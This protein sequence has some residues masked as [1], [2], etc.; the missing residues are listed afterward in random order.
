MLDVMEREIRA[1]PAYVRACLAPLRE[2]LLCLGLECGRVVMAGCGDSYYSAVAVAETFRRSSISVASV[3][4]QEAAQY[5]PLQRGDLVVLSSVS[6]TTRRTIEA[7][8]RAREARVGT[9]AITCAPASELARTCDAVL[10]LP[11]EPLSRS[12]PHTLDYTLTLLAQSL[13]AEAVGGRPIEDLDR[14]SDAL[15]EAVDEAFRVLTNALGD[16]L[17]RS[18]VF[19]L[20]AGA[21]LGTAMYGAAKLHEAGGRVA[22]YAESENFWHGTNFM[23][24][25]TDLVVVFENRLE[26]VATERLLIESLQ[27]LAGTVVYVGS[28]DIGGRHRVGLSSTSEFLAPFLMAIAPQVACLLLARQAHRQRPD[29]PHHDRRAR[30]LAAQAAWFKR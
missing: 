2:S 22:L 16:G 13:V 29:P 7:A 30:Q 19:Y 8:W 5:L 1:Q 24:R 27:R 25:P 17:A 21:D 6:G 28:K 10:L 26:S 4:S 3:T 11:Y 15:Q 23:L 20:G 14:L 18:Q 9:L 12:T